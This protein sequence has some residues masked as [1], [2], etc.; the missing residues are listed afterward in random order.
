MMRIQHP[1]FK[2]P[3]PS[4]ST[5]SS[6][7]ETN[8]N[9]LDEKSDAWA[10]LQWQSLPPGTSISIP[11]RNTE[12]FPKEYV[13]NWDGAIVKSMVE[14]RT[15]NKLVLICVELKHSP[16]KKLAINWEEPKLMR[17]FGLEKGDNVGFIVPHQTLRHNEKFMMR[18]MEGDGAMEGWAVLKHVRHA[19]LDWLDMFDGAY[20]TKGPTLDQCARIA[21]R[22]ERYI[23]AVNREVGHWWAVEQDPKKGM[24]YRE[25]RAF[26]IGN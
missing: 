5:S 6:E 10:H 4:F 2:P 18:K 15:D 14:Q 1:E 21:A 9:T 7:G 25:N 23:Q 11:I 13:E 26:Y 24:Y 17:F 12:L 19:Y 3:S 22:V 20:P 16:F 8:S